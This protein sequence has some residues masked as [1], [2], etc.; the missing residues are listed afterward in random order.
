MDQALLARV[1]GWLAAHRQEIIDDL[2]GLVRIPSV[3]VPDETVPPYG[4]A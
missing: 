4:Q 1:D 3:S 2:I